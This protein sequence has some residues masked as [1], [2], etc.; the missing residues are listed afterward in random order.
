MKDLPKTRDFE[1]AFANICKGNNWFR[2][3]KTFATKTKKYFYDTGTG[4][5]FVVREPVYQVLNCLTKTNDFRKLQDLNLSEN[6]LAEA[7]EEIFKAVKDE[8]ILSAQTV[9]SLTGPQVTHLEQK[10]QKNVQAVTLEITQKCNLRC[11]YCIYGDGHTDYRNFG[12]ED[13]SLDVALKAVDFLLEHG[14]DDVLYVGFYG[15]EPLLRWDI[16]KK[17]VEY[18][19]SKHDNMYFSMTSNMVLLNEEIA[20]FIAQTKH[21]TVMMSLDGPQNMHDANRVF[22]DGEGS[23]EKAMQGLRHLSE[24]HKRNHIIDAG[25]IMFSAVV[26][27]PYGNEKFDQIQDFFES[28]DWLPPLANRKVQIS[29][30]STSTLPTP[31]IPINE[32]PE[33]DLNYDVTLREDAIVKWEAMHDKSMENTFASDYLEKAFLTIHRRHLSDYPTVNYPMN[34]CCIPGAR[35]LYITTNGDFLPCE[36]MGTV[37]PIGNIQTGYDF[38]SIKKNYVNDFIKEAVTY[39]GECW[40][41]NLCKNCYINCFGEDGSCDFSYRHNMCR[42]TRVNLENDLIRYHEMLDTN[43]DFI[44]HLNTIKIV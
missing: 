8:H 4:K 44:Q 34:G 38:Q 29:Y 31:Y 42:A 9:T 23:F 26:S 20:E 19:K 37:T 39:C 18:T 1:A 5:I 15:G 21:F 10:L 16:I 12:T 28:L 14:T 43:A 2:L 36:R 40:A 25:T 27:K 35:K 3:G 30:V 33:N 6:V 32:R 7:F 11:K 13:M 22:P 41:I 24:A 17:V